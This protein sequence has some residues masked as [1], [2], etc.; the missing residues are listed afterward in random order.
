MQR[1]IVVCVE[2]VRNEKVLAGT[3]H[4]PDTGAHHQLR[5]SKH[6]TDRHKLSE[7]LGA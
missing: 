2:K 5:H 7:Q 1:L 3:V 6:R 4:T